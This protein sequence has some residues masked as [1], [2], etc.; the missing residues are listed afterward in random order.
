LL[1]DL[2]QKLFRFREGFPDL[3]RVFACALRI[4]RA[5]SSFAAYDRRNLL[6][7]SVRLKF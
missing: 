3:A 2:A 6:N 5:A 4:L 7:Q 1:V